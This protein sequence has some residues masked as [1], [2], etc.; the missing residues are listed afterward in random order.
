MRRRD[1][2]ISAST[3]FTWWK[4]SFGLSLYIVPKSAHLFF[5]LI[6]IINYPLNLRSLTSNI[7]FHCNNWRL[8]ISIEFISPIWVVLLVSLYNLSRPFPRLKKL[9]NIWCYLSHFWK[10]T[11]ILSAFASILLRYLFLLVFILRI[12]RPYFWFK[13]LRIIY[14]IHSLFIFRLIMINVNYLSYF[15]K[16]KFVISYKT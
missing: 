1:L 5:W 12:F 7:L 3:I 13:H 2:T 4:V 6:L 15:I 8:W 11:I 9:L 10:S 14:I 16:I